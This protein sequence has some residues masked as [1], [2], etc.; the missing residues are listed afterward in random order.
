MEP[1]DQSEPDFFLDITSEIC[2]MTFVKTKLLLERMAPGQICEVRLKGAEP[3]G[4]VPRSV[5]DH[6][7]TV[8]SLAPEG[9]DA[10]AEAVHRLVIRRN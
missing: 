4:N 6:G 3:L 5:R 2:P 8:L 1:Y 7:H 9:E 10:S